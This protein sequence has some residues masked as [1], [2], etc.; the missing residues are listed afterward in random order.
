MG[1][2]GILM[3]LA[4]KVVVFGYDFYRTMDE[5]ITLQKEGL[6]ALTWLGQDVSL[7]HHPSIQLADDPSVDLT[8]DPPDFAEDT[9]V[10]PLPR[11]VDGKARINT[12]K[13]LTWGSLA[14]YEIDP[15][16][17]RLM[18][19]LVDSAVAI[20][21][22]DTVSKFVTDPAPDPADPN[23]YISNIEFVES[24]SY[25][26]AALMATLPDVNKRVAA[27]S[28]ASL[29]CT[30]GTDTL[31]IELTI[32]LP[33]RVRGGRSLDNSLTLNTTI[34]PRN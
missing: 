3:V 15:V 29:D 2:M 28:V 31:E 16:N 24:A 12:D 13:S 6:L 26:S 17:H 8:T 18:R 25:P 33:G 1:I 4:Q 19:Y 23:Y 30:R 11:T 10:V 34:F 7:S 9:L 32:L 14:A 27:R 21:P 22:P 5:S 20:N